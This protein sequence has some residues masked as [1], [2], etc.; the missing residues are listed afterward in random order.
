MRKKMAQTIEEIR[1][2]AR[3]YKMANKEVLREKRKAYEAANR[4]A[5]LE[6]KRLYR[7]KNQEK[8][9]AYREKNREKIRASSA[10]Y[11]ALNKEKKRAYYRA[12]KERIKSRSAAWAES[13]PEKR[14]EIR[15]RWNKA[16]P[17]TKKLHSHKYIAKQ[18]GKDLDQ[19]LSRG[20]E[21]M[22]RLYALNPDKYRRK[23][24][25]YAK[26]NPER[27]RANATRYRA[28]KMGATPAWANRFLIDEIY[29]LAMLRT[30]ITGQLWEVDHM[31]PL[32]SDIVCGLHVES[33]LRLVLKSINSGKRNR[34][35]FDGQTL[36]RD[37]CTP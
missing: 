8:L 1:A 13:H 16:N 4:E 18:R 30:R 17:D 29:S 11:E 23:R 22:A 2:K 19:W 3:A 25:Q 28:A 26:A 33:N 34:H 10:A 6:K 7:E 9:R 5:I 14:L 31:V 20:R 32:C 37:Q 27:N 15:R 36:K 35:L 24:L 21:V 12:N